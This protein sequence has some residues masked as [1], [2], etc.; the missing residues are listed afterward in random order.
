MAVLYSARFDTAD[1]IQRGR[2]EVVRCAVYRSGQ[3]V[4]PTA[5]GSTVSIYDASGV[6]VV[7]E[8]DVTVVAD[9]ATYAL[10]GVVTEDLSYSRDWRIVWSLL[11]PDGQIHTFDNRMVLARRAPF[12]VITEQSIY[13]RVRALDPSDPAVISRRTE[14]AS[15][16]DDAWVRLVNRLVESGRRI[17]LIVDPSVLREVHLLLTLATVFDDLAARNPAHIEA[18]KSVRDQY[19]AA[20]ASLALPTDFDDDGDADVVNVPRGPVWAM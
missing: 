13:G 3:L 20:W 5:V 6:A 16:I 1:L 11:M 19:E 2:D 17:E 18:A 8:E 4:A 14:Y 15:V 12:P 10:P 7:D 9:V